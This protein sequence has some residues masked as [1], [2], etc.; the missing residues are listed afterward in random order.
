MGDDNAEQEMHRPAAALR[1][2]PLHHWTKADPAA[3]PERREGP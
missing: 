1:E 2:I 3:E